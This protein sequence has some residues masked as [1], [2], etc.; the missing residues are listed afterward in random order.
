MAWL[1]DLVARQ[2]R[3]A[4]L[5]FA[6]VA[7]CAEGT[8]ELPPGNGG[9]GGDGPGSG[10]GGEGGDGG[11]MVFPCG[12]DCS[13]IMAPTCLKSVC[14]EGQYLGPVGS[15]V[16][17]DDDVGATCDDAMFCTTDDTCN[18]MGDCIGGP[19]N[20]C[21]MEPDQCEQ[22]QCNEASQSCSL[23]PSMNGTFC[24]PTD[25]CL[26]NAT[27]LNG[28]CAGGT[29]KDCFFAPVPNECWVAVCDPMSGQCVPEP[30][31]GASG[32]PCQDPGQLCQVSMTCDGM[33]NCTGGAPKDCSALT[34]GCF[35]GVCDTMTGNCIQVP[36]PPG[37]ICAQAT[38][39]CNNGICDMNGSCNPVPTNEGG[40]CNDFDGCTSN[41]VCTM[42][43]CV[44]GTVINMCAFNDGCCPPG[45]D[46][47]NDNDCI[48]PNIMLCGFSSKSPLD[49]TPPNMSFNLLNGCTP[50]ITVQALFV[51]RGLQPGQINAAQLQGYIQNGGI[52][53]TEWNITDDVFSL[54][55]GAV[56]QGPLFIGSCTDC[57][58]L[59][60]QFSPND[61]FW[62]DNPFMMLPYSD[63]GCG[64]SVAAY[65]GITPIS[66][67]NATDV[68][69]AY[70]ELGTGRFWLT[71][72]DWQDNEMYPC[73]PISEQ[74][75]GYMMTHK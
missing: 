28:L 22:V 5:V 64:Y 10:G 19:V 63:S 46:D 42:G 41:T 4:V 25:L 73:T 68:S 14:N 67:W 66:G 45:C 72:F 7:A 62:Q 50:D 47:T 20:D 75:M 55:F 43:N 30:D 74:L 71:D 11:T 18:G 52:V 12:I 49:F 8:V 9:S 23:V 38:D 69:V 39:D 16:V 48:R 27:C 59:V 35:D 13:A 26:V 24:T 57:M 56:A 6:V 34:Q 44:G 65:P 32:D 53:L 1:G 37:G 31:A 61:P 15:C 17:V 36:I 3:A 51:T 29:P 60:N 58:P 33:G 70:R 54:A 21:G 2:G 40:P